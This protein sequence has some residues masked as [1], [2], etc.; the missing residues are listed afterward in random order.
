MIT[1]YLP[2][3]LDSDRCD[4][5]FSLLRVHYPLREVSESEAVDIARSLVLDY[6]EEWW[7]RVYAL[8]KVLHLCGPSGRGE[9]YFDR[10]RLFV[11]VVV[12][13]V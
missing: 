2:I 1:F 7:F 5:Y 13:A 11:T 9:W 12:G 3:Y 10:N 6:S 4:E 8:S